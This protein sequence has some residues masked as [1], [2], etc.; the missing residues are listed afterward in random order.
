MRFVKE[1]IE[2]YKTLT[3]A[4]NVVLYPIIDD[5]GMSNEALML[6]H[7]KKIELADK[8]LVLDINK[9]IGEGAYEELAYSITLGKL[10]ELKEYT[11]LDTNKLN[12]GFQ[13]MHERSLKHGV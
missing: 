1:I 10:V 3:K 12:V 11:L 13:M 6:L 9:Y 4:G 2:E 5:F 7:R 8:V